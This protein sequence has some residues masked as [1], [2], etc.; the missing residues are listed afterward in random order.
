[1]EAGESRQPSHCSLAT[2]AR[3]RGSHQLPVVATRRPHHTP[4]FGASG[5]SIAS[6]RVTLPAYRLLKDDFSSRTVSHR[7]RTAGRGCKLPTRLAHKRITARLW[8]QYA[9][10]HSDPVPFLAQP[11]RRRERGANSEFPCSCSTHRYPPAGPP[12]KLWTVIEL[13]T[14]VLSHSTAHYRP[15]SSR[16]PPDDGT[17]P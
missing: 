2:I 14:I 6:Q 5:L 8:L 4:V 16:R 17:I 12:C 3:M 15:M 11:M 9:V 7:P 1:M 10:S 13:G